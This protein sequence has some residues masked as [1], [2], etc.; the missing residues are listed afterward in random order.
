MSC[1][2]LKYGDY[3]WKSER[4]LVITYNSIIYFNAKSNKKQFIN[5]LAFKRKVPLEKLAGLTMS[6]HPESH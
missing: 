2:L 1:K 5:N 6:M 3:D 4:I